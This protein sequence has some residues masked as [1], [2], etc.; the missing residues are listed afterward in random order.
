MFMPRVI[1]GFGAT[2]WDSDPAT[3]NLVRY[4]SLALRSSIARDLA[5][6]LLKLNHTRRILSQSIYIRAGSC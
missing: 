3:A 2:I 4:S 5:F 6:N 1:F